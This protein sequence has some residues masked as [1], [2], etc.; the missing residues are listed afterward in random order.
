MDWNF[1]IEKHREALKSVLAMLVAMA[2]G[3]T[4]FTS[5]A[6]LPRHLHRAVLRLLRPAESAVRRLVIVA[7][8][9]LVVELSAPRRRRPGK[10][11]PTSAFLRKPGGTGILLPRG[12]RLP[13][14]RPAP[15]AL[16]LP[17]FDRLPRWNIRPRPPAANSVPRI[18][19]PGISVPFPVAARRP[20]S[21]GDPLDAG[22]LHRRLAALAAALDDLPRAARRF[23]R[24]RACRDAASVQDPGAGVQ[25]RK[26]HRLWPMRPGRPPG[27][28]AP[29]SRHASAVHETLNDLHGLA[30][31]AL[32]LRNDT[33]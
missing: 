17:L 25:G 1:A 27:W 26:L 28:R 6:T 21:P 30:F 32:E 5:P 2:G 18:L 10:R 33:S 14:A 13:A 11:K 31:W 9:S 20:L 24:W 22:R 7:A 16:A 8:R 23:A 3:G 19:A 12:M 4:A 29:G 15:R